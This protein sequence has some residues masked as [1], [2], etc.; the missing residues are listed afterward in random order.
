MKQSNKGRASRFLR[1][2]ALAAAGAGLIL[3]FGVANP[4]W[5]TTSYP[6]SGWYGPYTCPANRDFGAKAV[7]ATGSTNK[8]YGSPSGVT[9]T[10]S[11]TF[12][13]GTH[14]LITNLQTG[15]YRVVA[16]TTA[17]NLNHSCYT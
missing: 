7:F 10:H 11:G 13:P 3:T 8:I 17:T 14:V 4:A 5:A 15:Y 9:T 2:G 1:K 12:G 6:A 16:S